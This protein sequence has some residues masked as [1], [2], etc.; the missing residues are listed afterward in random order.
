MSFVGG[1]LKLKGGEPLKPA[2][3]VKKKKKEEK[4]LAAAPQGQPG[5]EKKEDD[6][7]EKTRK[8][9]HGYELKQDEKEDRRTE[10]ERKFEERFRKV[11][12]QMV[13][14]AANKSHRD[15]V[16]DFNEYLAALSEHHDIPK[17]GPG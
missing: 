5:D 4:A 12:E 17:V 16:K 14:K 6:P 1:K 15:R 2:G 11:E 7:A 9:L 8:A 3:G 10:A 13:K